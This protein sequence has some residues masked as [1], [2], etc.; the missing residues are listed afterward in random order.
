M[1]R[2]AG[3]AGAI[4]AGAGAGALTSGAGGT[5]VTSCPPDDQ[6]FYCKLSRFTGIVKMILFLITVIVFVI[7]LFYLWKSLRGSSATGKRR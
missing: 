4:A 6:S 3:A 5:T 2:G 7:A 1:G